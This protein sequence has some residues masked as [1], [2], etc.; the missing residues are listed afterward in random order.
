MRKLQRYRVRFER[1]SCKGIEEDLKE[2][3]N[4]IFNTVYIE[5]FLGKTTGRVGDD[6]YLPRIPKQSLFPAPNS[7]GDGESKLKLVPNGFG[8][9]SGFP[10]R[11]P[12]I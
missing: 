2:R 1:E 12:F 7:N 8:L 6:F 4:E 3:E 11:P 5:I 10:A 9:G